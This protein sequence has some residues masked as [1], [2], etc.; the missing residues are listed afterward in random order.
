MKSTHDGNPETSKSSKTKQPKKI[1]ISIDTTE[2]EVVRYDQDGHSLDFVVDPPESFRQLSDKVAE[3]LS[4]DARRL[5]WIAYG[6]WKERLKVQS[7]EKVLATPGFEVTHQPFTARAS[8]RLKLF[9][10]SS[11]KEL[12]TKHGYYH[13]NGKCFSFV[14]PD[15]L[16]E[17][18]YLGWR[19]TSDPDVDGF[20]N[21]I[22]SNPKLNS[23]IDPL[24]T[25]LI[26][27]EFSEENLIKNV[28]KPRKE[29]ANAA[30]GTADARTTEELSKT[31]VVPYDAPENDGVPWRDVKPSET[32][33]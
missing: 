19:P 23:P 24:K 4:R 28:I 16:R 14:R 22:S 17:R 11:G 2:E 10:N 1:Q 31:G 33:D 26:A 9:D 30:K 5:Y 6:M 20:A 8:E 25:E 32:D 12:E 15:E 27:V 7:G 3:K 29:R 13:K 21:P 18:G